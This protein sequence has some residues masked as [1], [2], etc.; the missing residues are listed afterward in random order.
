MGTL[1]PNSKQSAMELLPLVCR[2]LLELLE[3]LEEPAVL[4]AVRLSLDPSLPLLL[5]SVGVGWAWGR[6]AAPGLVRPSA[7]QC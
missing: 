3:R 4:V 5:S 6:R 2:F 7:S 1:R